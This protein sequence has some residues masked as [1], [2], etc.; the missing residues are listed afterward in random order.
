MPGFIKTNMDIKIMVLYAL[1]KF[2]E[3]PTFDELAEVL[4]CDEG[5]N[6]FLLTQSVEELLL[7]N[8]IKIEDNCYHLTRRGKDNLK[9]CMHQLPGSVQKK[10]DQALEQVN[11][12]QSKRKFVKTEI[13][14]RDQGGVM[15]RLS[16]SNETGLLFDSTMMIPTRQEG[17]QLAKGF[18][19]DPITFF[20]AL[21]EYSMA[22]A[23]PLGEAAE[24]SDLS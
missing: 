23:A 17:E 16:F 11:R 14:E 3:P 19:E 2:Y 9:E 22:M 13:T 24:E 18:W 4:L 5:L 20:Y 8:N 7:P 6:Y 21:R 1:S 10:C 12:K 15:L